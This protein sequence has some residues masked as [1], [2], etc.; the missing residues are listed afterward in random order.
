MTVET[1]LAVDSEEEMV[2]DLAAAATAVEE[3]VKVVVRED[4]RAGGT[5]WRRII[6]SALI[7][8]FPFHMCKC[9][10]GNDGV[11]L[12]TP[13][14]QPKFPCFFTLTQYLPCSGFDYIILS[15][16]FVWSSNPSRGRIL[17]MPV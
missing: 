14:S 11:F 17:D 10:R 1:N 8:R 5:V 13:T 16:L 2:S 6:Q 7:I 4:S 12:D 3:E 9:P 15:T